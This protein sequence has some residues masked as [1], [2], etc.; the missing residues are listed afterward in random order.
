MLEYL[1]YSRVRKGLMGR[2]DDKQGLCEKMK[3][4]TARRALFNK[5]K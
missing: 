2:K 1:G 5:R 4:S 3:L